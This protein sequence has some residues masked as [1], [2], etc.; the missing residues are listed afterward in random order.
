MKVQ[1]VYY[2]IKCDCCGQLLDPDSYWD[3]G[4]EEMAD[5][6]SWKA[7]EPDKHYCPDCYEWDDEDHLVTKDGKKWDECGYEITD[8]VPTCM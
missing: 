1:K 7:L 8:D 4:L 6:C 2:N 3:D 5:E